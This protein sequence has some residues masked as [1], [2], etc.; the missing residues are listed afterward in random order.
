MQCSVSALQ[1]PTNFPSSNPFTSPILICSSNCNLLALEKKVNAQCS[2]IFW[3]ITVTVRVAYIGDNFVSLILFMYQFNVSVQISAILFNAEYFD[4]FHWKFLFWVPIWSISISD[5]ISGSISV[6]NTSL[7]EYWYA[8]GN[9][10][11]KYH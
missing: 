9:T 2:S 10:F 11:G 5:T 6:S 8:T 3:K 1:M 7:N 4:N